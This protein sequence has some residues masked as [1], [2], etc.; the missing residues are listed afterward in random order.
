VLFLVASEDEKDS[1]EASPQEIV[2]QP[3]EIWIATPEKLP[4]PMIRLSKKEK[5][6]A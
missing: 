4:L 5:I 2:E 3:D 6:R 1:C